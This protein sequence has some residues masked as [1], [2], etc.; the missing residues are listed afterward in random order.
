M[1]E[2]ALLGATLVETRAW[3]ILKEAVS[4]IRGAQ[5]GD[6]SVDFDA[7]G[8]ADQKE[9][10]K[11]AVSTAITA[12]EELSGRTPHDADYHQTLIR[13]LLQWSDSGFG[14]PD[15]SKSLRAFQPTAQRADGVEH[16]VVFPTRIQNGAPGCY[17]E[18]LAVRVVW[19]RWLDEVERGG[20]ANPLIVPLAFEDFT[21]GFDSHSAVLFPE[22]VAAGTASASGNWGALFCDRE[23]A[24]YSMVVSAATNSLHLD[25]PE[26]AELLF[27]DHQQCMQS[28]A[29]WDMLHDRGHSRGYL[30][31]DPFLVG[32]RAPI[33]IYALEELRCDLLAFRDAIA[34]EHDGVPQGRDVQYMIILDRIIRFPV[35]GDRVGNYDGLC[36]QLLFSYFH[37]RGVIDW[38]DNCLIVDWANISGAVESLLAEIDD[39]YRSGIDRPKIVHWLAAYAFVSS[40]VPPHPASAWA[41]GLGEAEFLKEPREL[42][43]SVLP[44][45]FPLS[46]FYV[47]LRRR[48]SGVITSVKGITSPAA[49]ESMAG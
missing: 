33:W 37:A 36:G 47:A 24:R 20:Y 43:D 30:P 6:G 21:A 19:P 28:F 17:L 16:L 46:L 49:P 27:Y 45:E 12:I 8:R 9:Q 29:L 10:V 2:R 35:T 23:A 32:Q 3:P 22:S 14:V 34:L 41:K 5:R 1:T 44:D 38:R 18:A 40:Y 31:F 26:Q 11:G 48:L 39:M 42:V 15:F 7:P 25:L 4:S 13:D